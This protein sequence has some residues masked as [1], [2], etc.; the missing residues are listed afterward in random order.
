MET[1]TLN[2]VH[3]G[4]S[5]AIT[6]RPFVPDFYDKAVAVRA[7]DKTWFTPRVASDSSLAS[8]IPTNDNG[9]TRAL[10]TN[11]DII[12]NSNRETIATACTL[13]T[14]QYDFGKLNPD[15][16]EY[17][18][19]MA[20]VKATQAN[21][22][23]YG[24]SN[25]N[26]FMPVGGDENFFAGSFG[27]DTYCLHNS[28]ALIVDFG[29]GA[30]KHGDGSLLATSISDETYNRFDTG[31][32]Q[33]QVGR[34]Y[35]YGSITGVYF[36]NISSIANQQNAVFDI[37][38]TYTDENGVAQ[39]VLL[40]AVRKDT[41]K[42]SDNISSRTWKS[43]LVSARVADF[44]HYS[45][46]EPVLISVDD[47]K[48]E[49]ADFPAELVAKLVR[50]YDIYDQSDFYCSAVDEEA[51]H[52]NVPAELRYPTRD[53]NPVDM[54][55]GRTLKGIQNI[56]KKGLGKKYFRAGDFFDITFAGS[57]ELVDGASSIP[58]SSIPADSTWRVVCLGINHNPEIEGYNRGHFA[59]GRNTDNVEIAFYGRKMNATS[60]NAGGWGACEMRT[61]LNST[62]YDALPE[63]LRAVISTSTKYT[64]NVGGRSTS[65]A[66]A[67]NVTATVD[68]IWLLAFHEATGKINN[69]YANKFESDFQSQYD[70][71]KNGH[72]LSRLHQNGVSTTSW[73]LRS[74]R[75]GGSN[76]SIIQADGSISSSQA[77]TT[78][79]IVPC[80]TIG[81]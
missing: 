40:P 73:V 28:S 48:H 44:Y 43:N 42:T 69:F 64:D 55:V 54:L 50:L 12:C 63:D 62:F 60:T 57:V 67:D 45:D 36:D 32:Y 41:I 3:G 9:N 81:G 25:S 30:V 74:N 7:D 4:E 17:F 37:A 71:Y 27:L 2:Y 10:S 49:W 66:A 79:S 51:V 53:D 46:G 77:T 72:S 33:N 76:F 1:K 5:F 13:V 70:Y 47:F 75:S 22:T 29:I 58:A 39:V 26:Y 78:R 38:V 6:L 11:P 20:S 31:S 68:N 8:H 52:Q 61:W 15:G 35:I 16:T 14:D 56:F 21:S 18:T 34:L 23:I 19:N 80:F 65:D 59:I 24:N